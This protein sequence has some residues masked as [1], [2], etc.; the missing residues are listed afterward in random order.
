[1]ILLYIKIKNTKQILEY[2]FKRIW[3]V[4]QVAC[5]T[6]GAAGNGKTR[7]ELLWQ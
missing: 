1:L 5:R 7:R 6:T 4:G 2:A 3:S